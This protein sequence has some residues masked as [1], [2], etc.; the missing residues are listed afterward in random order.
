MRESL[1]VFGS[2]DFIAEGDVRA[3]GDSGYYWVNDRSATGTLG[4]A[5]PDPCGASPDRESDIR[6]EI[7]MTYDAIVA[8]DTQAGPFW[9][10]L[11]LYDTAQDIT[12]TARFIARSEGV[13]TA[14]EEDVGGTMEL[15][16]DGRLRF[17]DNAS[18]RAAFDGSIEVALDAEGH[19]AGILESD[20]SIEGTW[21]PD[22]GDGAHPDVLWG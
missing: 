4:G 20:L 19:I 11:A 6:G 7:F 22:I 1:S 16:I 10:T 18:G 17:T 15:E 5:D 3:I 14:F 2:F 21:N 12:Y 8:K 13:V 9:G